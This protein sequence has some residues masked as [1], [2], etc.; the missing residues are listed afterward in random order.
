MESNL[1]KKTQIEF[2]KL[3]E[4]NKKISEKISAIRRGVKSSEN[5]NVLIELYEEEVK[6]LIGTYVNNS[7]I[8]GENMLILG[9]N[10]VDFNLN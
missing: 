6:T 1:V 3:C 9:L 7:I 4:E 8:I 10:E 2:I 5:K